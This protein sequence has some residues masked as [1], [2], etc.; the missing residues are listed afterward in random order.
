[1]HHRLQAFPDLVESG[2][3][4]QFQGC[5]A[6]RGHH[7]GTVA[8]VAVLVLVELGIADPVPAFQ[9]PTL[10]QQ[11]QQCFWCGAQARQEEVGG[12][13][14]LAST[15]SRGDH[16]HDPAGAMPVFLDV[17]GSLFRP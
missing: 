8:A 3:A 12:L 1:M 4:Q 11:L 16:F 2:Q 9:A 15:H 6:Q 14:R 10:S 17:I 5:G 13:K 7:A